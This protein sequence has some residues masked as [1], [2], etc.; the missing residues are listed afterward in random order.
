MDNQANLNDDVRKMGELIDAIEV[1]MLTTVGPDGTLV[2]RPLH[3]LRVTGSGE[4]LFF[5]QASSGKADDLARKSRVN[6]AYADTGKQTYLSVTGQ[7]S[8]ERDRA[9]V[10][11]LW[12]P[13]HR[14]FFPKGR[15]DPDLAILRVHPVSGEYWEASGNVIGR[16]IDFA[17]ALGGEGP[18]ALGEHGRLNLG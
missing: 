6:V 2:S 12:K 13:V 4:L 16:A 15:D 7:A 8:I 14:A 18:D 3:T 9:L 17:R 11:D 5:T 10:E 1:A